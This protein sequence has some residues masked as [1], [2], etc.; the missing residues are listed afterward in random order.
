MPHISVCPR[1]QTVR[2]G[3]AARFECFAAGNPLPTIYWLHNGVMIES[4]MNG[5]DVTPDGTLT[6][7]NVN[8]THAGEMTCVAEN[9][10]G[11]HSF[12]ASLTV[13]GIYK[14]Q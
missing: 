2:I 1:P 4:G 10:V 13:I 14:I 8:Q 9:T 6:I 5:F 7:A 12:V 11:V 3:Q